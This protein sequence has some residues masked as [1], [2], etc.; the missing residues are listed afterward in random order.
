VRSIRLQSGLV[1]AEL[2]LSVVLLSSAALLTRSF[3]EYLEWDPGFDREPLLA[4]A[5]LMN[6][7]MD[8]ELAEY[9]SVI[10]RSEELIAAVPGVEAVATASAGLLFGGSDGATPFIADGEDP[11]GALPTARWFDIGP[12]Y[13]ET[14]GLPMVRGRE[15]TEM[16]T[17]GTAL[18]AV[19]N[20]T[21]ARRAWPGQNAV[22]KMLRLPEREVTFEVVGVVSDAL[23]M[24]PGRAPDAEVYWSNRQLGRPATFYLV[25]AAGDPTGVAEGVLAAL[26]AADPDVATGTPFPLEAAAQ[27]ALVRPRFQAI[28][29]L[30]FAVVALILSA[31]GVYAVVSYAVARRAREV[32]IRVALG[33]GNGDVV[34]LMARSNM[35]VA[36]VGVVLGL[37]GALVA[38]RLIQ[39]LIPGVSPADPLSLGVGCLTL[40]AV[41]ALAILVPAG[42]A[43]RVDPLE[44]MRME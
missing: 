32:G 8:V 16:D 9:M 27:R 5:T 37:G 26:E 14:L 18:V 30:T 33:A 35:A 36:L 29:L 2:A 23:P 42:R 24:E 13:F 11:S 10:R 21:L 19:V 7:G 44:A 34:A 20:E 31:G 39:S 38:G 17:E 25:R 12:G 4:V 41:T 22:G 40:M 3:I 6:T 28:I 1:V 43:A 15:F